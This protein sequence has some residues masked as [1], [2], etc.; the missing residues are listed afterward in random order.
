MAGIAAG[1]Q[2]T[3]PACGFG[4]TCP[5]PPPVEGVAP[6]ADLIAIQVFSKIVQSGGVKGIEFTPITAPQ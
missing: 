1:S 6:G 3:Y 2:I 4:M 5:P